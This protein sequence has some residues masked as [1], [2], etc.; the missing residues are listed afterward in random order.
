[1][2]QSELHG[3]KG[4]PLIRRSVSRRKLISEWAVSAARA[5][6]RRIQWEASDSPRE[7]GRPEALRSLP[8]LSSESTTLIRRLG[9]LID[10]RVGRQKE[11][12][13]SGELAATEMVKRSASTG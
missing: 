7:V 6:R 5:S 11:Q 8:T 2:D 4:L 9:A 12:I 13:A 3:A 1:M 10:E